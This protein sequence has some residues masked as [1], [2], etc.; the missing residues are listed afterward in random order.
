MIRLILFF[1]HLVIVVI[2]SVP[3]LLVGTL[4]GKLHEPSRNVA[5][6]AFVRRVYKNVCWIAGAKTTVLGL[7]NLPPADEPVLYIGNHRSYFDILLSYPHLKGPTGYVAKIEMQK[8][9][10]LR[11]WMKHVDCVFLDR[12]DPREGMKAILTAIDKV[13]NGTSIFIFPEGTRNYGETLLPFKEGSF[14]I[15]QKTGC[16]I[17]PV[18]QNNTAAL[19]E[20]NRFPYFKSAHTVLEFG[21]PIDLK[22]LSAEDKKHLGSYVQNIVQE[23]YDKNK[24]LV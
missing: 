12:D 18:V 17:V 14:K 2:L 23:I 15:A 6:R 22:D 19:L 11:I 7:E 24:A 20:N 8:I 10:L 5:A 4:W 21:K 9:P 16:R 1:I 3:V 13:K